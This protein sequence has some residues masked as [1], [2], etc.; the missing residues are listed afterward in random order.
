MTKRPV[1]FFIIIVEM[2]M[3]EHPILGGKRLFVKFSNCEIKRSNFG[4]VGSSAGG[5]V[6]LIF[7]QQVLP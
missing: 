2:V 1:G 7:M 3:G 4:S 6:L 5:L